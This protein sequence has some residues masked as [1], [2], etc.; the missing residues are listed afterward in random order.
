MLQLV[1][2][3]DDLVVQLDNPRQ[4]LVF[5]QLANLLVQHFDAATGVREEEAEEA[6]LTEHGVDHHESTEGCID[7]G[8]QVGQTMVG[9]VGEQHGIG[10]RSNSV[11]EDGTF[12]DIIGISFSRG[13]VE[14]E[15]K[16][17]QDYVN[18]NE[19]ELQQRHQAHNL[20]TSF[21]VSVNP[22]ES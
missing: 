6:V 15:L 18:A 2:K 12:G 4:V 9:I 22:R 8:E 13:G 14:E 10:K 19:G 3:V 1:A 20:P 11:V 7:V 21:T 17:G 16:D 5:L